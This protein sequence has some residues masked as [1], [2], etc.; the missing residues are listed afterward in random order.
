MAGGEL[1]QGTSSDRLFPR[2]RI[3]VSVLF[4]VNGYL[5]GNWAPK[6]PEFLRRLSL[7]ES[8][9]GLLLLLLGAGALSA[10]P[11]AGWLIARSGSSSIGKLTAIAAVPAILIVTL[12]NNIFTAGV[13]LFILGA[14]VAAMDVAM[15]ANAV[16]V[17]RKFRRAIMSSCHGFWSLGGLV[18]AATG[19][20]LIENLGLFGHAWLVTGISAAGVFLCLNA[21]L[22][23]RIVTE[24]TV[25]HKVRLPANPLPYVLGAMALFSMVPEGA[26]LDWGALYLRQE[27]GAGLDL[28]GFGYAAFSGAMAIMRFAGDP[29]RQKF[30]AVATMRVCSLAAIIGL[31]I[32]GTAP[33]AIVATIGFALAGLGISNLVPI[34]FSAAGNLPGLPPG[35]GISMVTFMGYSGILFAPSLIGFIAEHTGLGPIFAFLPLPLCVVFILSHLAVHADKVADEPH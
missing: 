21:I 27:L 18:G 4:F 34:L 3:A 23:D 11:V 20:W 14:L 7:S 13:V 22:E 16:S 8:D 26:V 1:P 15:N 30:G 28:S 17:E 35:I 33:N 25:V 31:L 24:G 29:L 5:L 12:P 10:M 2:E 9:L 32:A 19:G 6:V